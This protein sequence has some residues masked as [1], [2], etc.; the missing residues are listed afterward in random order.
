MAKVLRNIWL[1]VL[2]ILG[3]G[4]LLVFAPPMALAWFQAMDQILN[5]SLFAIMTG[6]TLVATIF[7]YATSGDT[8]LEDSDDEPLGQ[9]AQ[10]LGS[11][12][13]YFLVGLALSVAIDPFVEATVL[14]LTDGVPDALLETPVGDL[15][16]VYLW[17]NAVLAWSYTLLSSIWVNVAIF[18]ELALGIVVFLGGFSCLY[19]AAGALKM[20]E[21]DSTMTRL[22]EWLRGHKDD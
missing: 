18:L 1:F 14:T 2:V 3:L 6:L 9:S 16:M 20:S 13:T 19:A 22:S 8:E 10:A 4:I 21:L 11:A 5:P 15:A 7:V 17:M 12:L